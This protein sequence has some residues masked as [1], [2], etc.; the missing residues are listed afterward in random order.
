LRKIRIKKF[1]GFRYFR[2]KKPIIFMKEPKFIKATFEIVKKIEKPQLY[3][4]LDSLDLSP[5]K[6]MGIYQCWVSITIL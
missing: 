2:N 3:T 6:Q 4:K 5:I 1:D